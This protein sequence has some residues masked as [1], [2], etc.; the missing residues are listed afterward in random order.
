MPYHCYL[1]PYYKTNKRLYVL[2]GLKKCFSSMDGFIHNNPGQY[3]VIGGH[4]S[5]SSDKTKLMK[6][7]IR[8]FSEETGHQVI[9]TNLKTYIRKDYTI[10]YYL[11]DT[12]SEFDNLNKINK[13]SNYFDP[14]HTELNSVKWFRFE[15]AKKIM[16]PSL[17][18]NLPCGGLSKMSEDYLKHAFNGS[19]KW[20]AKELQKIMNLIKRRTPEL[21]RTD[22]DIILRDLIRKNKKSS[23]FMIYNTAFNDYV[24]K[25]SYI[26]WYDDL[27]NRSLL[28]NSVRKSPKSKTPP[29]RFRRSSPKSKSPPRRFAKSPGKSTRKRTRPLSRYEKRERKRF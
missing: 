22:L 6:S 10:S 1:L 29:K 14:A 18:N 20:G 23:Y 13:K 9:Q 11:V 4:C 21:S 5:K 12:R 26:D 2:L 28:T 15:E 24:M 3:V 7:S 27:L 25:R 19:V 16:E 17:M 8:E